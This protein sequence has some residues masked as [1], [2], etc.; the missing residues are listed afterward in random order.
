MGGGAATVSRPPIWGNRQPNGAPFVQ[1]YRELVH[2]LGRT[3]T[4]W[5]GAGT[6]NLSTTR[7]I[8]SSNPDH[9]V[10]NH[11]LGCIWKFFTKN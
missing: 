8:P 6:Y 11:N 1:S 9:S 3:T 4:H 7:R 2:T 5:H 10:D